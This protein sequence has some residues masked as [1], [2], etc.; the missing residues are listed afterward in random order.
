MLGHRIDVKRN[1]GFP[2]LYGKNFP[3]VANH[4]SLANLKNERNLM[5]QKITK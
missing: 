3:S 2:R 1:M 5:I 4:Y